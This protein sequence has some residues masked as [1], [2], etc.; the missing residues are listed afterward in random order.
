MSKKIKGEDGKVY[1]EKK[2]WYKRWWAWVL[3]II[4]AICVWGALSGKDDNKD[5]SASN[6]PRSTQKDNSNSKDDEAEKKPETVKNTAKAVTLGAGTYKVGD[7]IQPGRYV[8]KALSGSGNLTSNGDS[9]INAILGTTTDNDLDQVTS[10]TATLSKGEKVKIEG[11]E[12]TSFTPTPNKPKFKTTLTAGS[13]IVGQ[14]IKPGHYTIKAVQGSGNLGT[15][16]SDVNEI[17]GTTADS[18]LGQVT[19]VSVDLSK[20]QILT[21]TLQEIE[22][23]K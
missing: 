18:D 9:D 6:S 15:N 17:L 16:D 12:Q 14:D 20:G 2:P 4:C 11:I 13:W 7:Q 1:V 23:S 19:H 8:I 21:T 10:Y 22:L 3:F 5:S